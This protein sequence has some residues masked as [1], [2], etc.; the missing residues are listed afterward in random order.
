EEQAGS[1][2][3]RLS[4]ADQP[5]PAK[6]HRHLVGLDDGDPREEVEHAHERDPPVHAPPRGV[7]DLRE[8]P[9]QAPDLG[10]S[11]APP[12]FDFSFSSELD[13]VWGGGGTGGLPSRSEKGSESVRR[14]TV[15]EDPA[16]GL[17]DSS[18]R[19]YR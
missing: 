12:H 1:V 3:R 18:E 7:D 9:P 14:I 19:R 10:R 4:L 8:G 15:V 6:D 16:S 11:V 17:R 5:T 2:L 13:F